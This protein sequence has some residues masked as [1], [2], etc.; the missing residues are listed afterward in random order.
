MGSIALAGLNVYAGVA[1]MNT[2]TDENCLPILSIEYMCN[3]ARTFFGIVHFMSAGSW[4]LSAILDVVF[5]TQTSN[6]ENDKSSGKSNAD[7]N[8]D[9]DEV[10]VTVQQAPVATPDD[11][12]SAV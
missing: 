7:A 2:T 11:K 9:D 1:M 5:V 6:N 8:A 10:I 4:L 3:D 12:V